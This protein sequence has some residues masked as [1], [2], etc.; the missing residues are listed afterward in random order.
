MAVYKKRVPVI[1]NAK[2]Y[3]GDN[4]DAMNDWANRVKSTDVRFFTAAATYPNEVPDRKLYIIKRNRIDIY[5]GVESGK[6]IVIDEHGEISMCQS[7]E[8][9]RLY[10]K[11]E[12]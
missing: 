2:Q 12:E 3:D 6:Y 10:E 1:V 11:L 8:F 4:I 5:K 9:H 7:D